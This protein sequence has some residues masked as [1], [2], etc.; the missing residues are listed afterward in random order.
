MACFLPSTAD[1]IGELRNRFDN[2]NW[3]N[4]T[5]RKNLYENSMH[6]SINLR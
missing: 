3:I 6:F 4:K 5:E 2:E 1:W